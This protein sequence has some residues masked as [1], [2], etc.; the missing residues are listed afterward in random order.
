MKGLMIQLM[1]ISKISTGWRAGGLGSGFG[2]INFWVC[3]VLDSVPAGLLDTCLAPVH[4]CFTL[5][6]TFCL[7]A[8]TCF[9]HWFGYCYDSKTSCL[10]TE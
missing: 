5:L 4:A 6:L 1:K 10:L 2:P 3:M 9:T 8:E 7:W